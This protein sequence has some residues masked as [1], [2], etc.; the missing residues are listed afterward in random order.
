M[1][2]FFFSAGAARAA[3]ADPGRA[4]VHW[5]QFTLYTSAVSKP[6]EKV[7]KGVRLE[8][9]FL[10]KHPERTLSEGEA[11]VEGRLPC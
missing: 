7:S 11:G 2:D 1:A 5:R 6:D 8:H 4:E 10:G 9:H 3:D